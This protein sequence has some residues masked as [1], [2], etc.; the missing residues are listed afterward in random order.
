NVW[1]FATPSMRISKRTRV[2]SRPPSTRAPINHFFPPSLPQRHHLF[3][4]V[5]LAAETVNRL[6]V[7]DGTDAR[8]RGCRLDGGDATPSVRVLH[9][10]CS[11]AELGQGF[12]GGNGVVEVGRPP[13]RPAEPAA[14]EAAAPCSFHDPPPP[15]RS[16]SASRA[17]SPTRAALQDGRS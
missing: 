4:E 17:P 14:L 9:R 16:T 8:L 12:A 3:V 1:T 11:P 13:P 5:P 10:P 6:K 15:R 2:T 7:H